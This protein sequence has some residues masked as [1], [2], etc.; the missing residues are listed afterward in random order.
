MIIPA[1][2]RRGENVKL[3]CQYDLEGDTL[4]S[5]K[6]YKG[7]REFYRFTPKKDPSLQTFP[8]PGIY[9]EVTNYFLIKWLSELIISPA[10]VKVQI[11]IFIVKSYTT[12]A[13]ANEC[14]HCV[15]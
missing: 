15:I 9:V 2:V 3:I 8:I 6:W 4:Y 12:V 1:A 7:K 14:S 5:L 13:T 10:N 11:K